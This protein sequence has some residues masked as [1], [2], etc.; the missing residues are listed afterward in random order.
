MQVEQEKIFVF[1]KGVV[2]SKDNSVASYLSELGITNS[3]EKVEYVFDQF[4]SHRKDFKEINESYTIHEKQ[5]MCFQVLDKTK[6]F[7]RFITL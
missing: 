5:D 7:I 1:L 3:M 6:E 2:N 4:F